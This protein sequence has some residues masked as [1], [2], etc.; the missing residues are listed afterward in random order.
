M[1]SSKYDLVRNLAQPFNNIYDPF[2]AHSAHVANNIFIEHHMQ[3]CEIWII[4]SINMAREFLIT[5][6]NL[7]IERLIYL[8]N[9]IC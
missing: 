3:A 8:S 2:I 4:K 9:N 1:I 6:D 7:T 5:K